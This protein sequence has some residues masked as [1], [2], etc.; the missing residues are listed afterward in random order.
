M[1]RL[2]VQRLLPRTQ[3]T[4]R[5][6]PNWTAVL[7]F[8]GLAS[9]HVFIATTAFLHQRWEGYMSCIFAS[10]FTV[11][12]IASWRL[13]GEITLLTVEKQLRVRT[14]FN[15][16]Y[17]E[18]FVA[19]S[20]IRGVRLTMFHPNKPTAAQIEIVCDYE[21]IEC[22]PTTVPREEALC[23]ALNIG[24]GLTKVYSDAFGPA[25]ERL[26]QLPPE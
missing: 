1:Q 17:F 6:P 8:V 19:F 25:A 11:I 22:P 15:R 21:V 9:L 13:R 16:I 4:L 24:V 10:A 26:D 3:V 5:T 20:R 14:G 7:F 2:E 18:R 23:L 12:A